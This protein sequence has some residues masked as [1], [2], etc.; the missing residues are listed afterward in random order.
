MKKK[1]TNDEITVVW[2]PDLCIHSENCARG[3][4]SVFNPNVRPWVNME[5][6][7]SA[8]IADQVAKCPSGALSIMN[9]NDQSEKPA[10]K[11]SVHVLT[12]GPLRV[13]GPCLVTLANGSEELREKD[14]F[15][16]RCG[17]SSNRPFCDGSHKK[18]G[19]KG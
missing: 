7:T 8:Q 4:G 13:V 12:D 15:L 11:A 9:E 14:V 19:F 18:E 16:C 3:L 6:G 17:H 10:T 5:G 1:Y 2:R